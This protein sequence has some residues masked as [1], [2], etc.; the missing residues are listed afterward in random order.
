MRPD[1]GHVASLA[2][3][4]LLRHVLLDMES[5]VVVAASFGSCGPVSGVLGSDDVGLDGEVGHGLRVNLGGEG[6]A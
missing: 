1:D 4:I 6:T 3:R 2:A 5:Q